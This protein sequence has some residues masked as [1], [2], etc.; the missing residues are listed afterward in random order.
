MIVFSISSEDVKRIQVWK[1]RNKDVGFLL[2]PNFFFFFFFF[3]LN[4]CFCTFLLNLFE[5]NNCSVIHEV[6]P[7][8][9]VL[10]FKS[11]FEKRS[12][13]NIILK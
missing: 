12:I 6:Q 2:H 1:P 8:K 13:L 3:F 11:L 5:T 9:M 4:M 7:F 10:I